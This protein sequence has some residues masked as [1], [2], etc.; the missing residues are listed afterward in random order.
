MWMGVWSPRVYCF[1]SNWKEAQ[2][3][4]ATLQRA[5]DQHQH[6][7]RGVTFFYFT[8]NMTTYYTFMSGSSKSP[9]IHSL[10]EDIKLLEIELEIVLEVIHVPGTT[11]ISEGTDGLSTGIWSTPLHQWPDRHLLLAEIFAPVPFTRDVGDWAVLE[12]G[13]D[14]G[15]HWEHWSWAL[16]WR[17]ED[18]LDRLTVWAPP[19]E[20]A[21]PHN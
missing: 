15:V 12:A 1:S 2:T 9:S 5:R 7:L 10:L 13:F 8:D 3:L 17:A 6:D 21:P 18:C 11:I 16:E 14:P 19:P 4:Y 20:V